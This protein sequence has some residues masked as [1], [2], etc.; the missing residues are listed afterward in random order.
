[1]IFYLICLVLSVFGFYVSVRIYKEKHSGKPM[2][3]PIDGP[4]G[5]CET[6]LTSKY[7]KIAGIGVEY[8]GA[9]FYGTLIVIFIKRML[10]AYSHFSRLD[11][12]A[13]GVV[14][15]GLLFTIYLFIIQKFVIKKWCTWCLFSAGTTVSIFIV[16]LIKLLFHW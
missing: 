5:S 1:M 13:F 9:V 10:E 14:C 15:C 4:E 11:L 12:F 6:V 3:C 2:V 8:L 7:S 16:L